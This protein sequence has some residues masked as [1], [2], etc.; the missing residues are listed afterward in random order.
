VE[1]VDRVDERRMSSET[2][3][4]ISRDTDKVVEPSR[5]R[6]AK[7]ASTIAPSSACR[8]IRVVDYAFQPVAIIRHFAH[9]AL[10]APTPE[11]PRS[12]VSLTT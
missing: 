6:A 3:R 2:V 10:G 7:S 8:Q 11:G 5:S 9:H 12:D 4:A 1:T